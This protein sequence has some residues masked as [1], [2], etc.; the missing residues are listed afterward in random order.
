M[1]N[2]VRKNFEGFTKHDIKMAQETRRLQGMIGRPTDREF[3]GMVR[4]KLIANFLVTV[5]DV[6]NANQI[7][8]TDLANLRGKMTRSKDGLF[9]CSVL[10]T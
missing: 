9:S 1:V 2:T 6:Q 10:P 8:G 7:F 5:H 3:A 4:E